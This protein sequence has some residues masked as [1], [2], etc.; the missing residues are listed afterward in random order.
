MTH[1]LNDKSDFYLISQSLK[2]DVSKLADGTRLPTVRDLAAKYSTTQYS[3]QQAI[4]LLKTEGLVNT[5]IGRGTFAGKAEKNPAMEEES[6]SEEVSEW[7]VLTLSHMTPSNRS[8]RITRLLHQRFQEKNHRS[9]V[10]TY[11][12]SSDAIE[13]I[14]SGPKYKAC[15]IQPRHS[16]IPVSLLA[17]L[18]ERSDIV[19][20][21]GRVLES[22]NIDAITRDRS[23][24]VELALRHLIDF[25]HR[26]ICLISEEGLDSPGYDD[27][28]RVFRTL[29]SWAGLPDETDPVI[30]AP[31][32]Q[33]GFVNLREQLQSLINQ[34]G[35]FPF[36][37]AVIS[38]NEP[39]HQLL[40][41]FT[42]AQLSVPN[43][44]SIVCLRSSDDYVGHINQITTVGRSSM[45]VVDALFQQIE[46]RIEHPNELHRTIYDPPQLMERKSTAVLNDN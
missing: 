40:Q 9:L 45:Q 20:V 8:D 13:M 15:I 24:S 14:R 6:V 16:Q 26:K 31:A 46:W 27:V 41:N 29:H 7:N 44:M 43:D 21:E 1:I 35:R 33:I 2:K 22:L 3:V 34:H 38:G 5:H 19:I 30:F 17:I 28:V 11:G 37:A 25:G 36:T 10:L 39:G 4:Q 23:L 12:E 32:Q 18:R 42:K